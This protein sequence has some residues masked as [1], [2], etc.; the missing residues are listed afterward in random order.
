[1]GTYTYIAT[2]TMGLESLVAKEVRNL[3]YETTVENGKVI[4][5][6]GE[7]ALCR[8]NLWLRTSDRVKLKIGS[9]TATSFEELFEE[10]KNLPWEAFIPVY[11]E[12]PVVG[13]SVKSQLYSV[14]DCQRIVKKA[15]VERLKQTYNQS[16]FNEDGPLFKIEVALLKDEVTLTLDTTGDGLHKR[17]YRR[18]HSEAPLKETLASAMI[19]LTNW[20]PHSD[21]A[22]LDPFCGSGTI[23]IEAAM[24]AKNIAPGLKRSFQAEQ[25]PF[26]HEDTWVQAREEAR[27]LIDDA[28]MPAIYGS[29]R[30]ARMTKLASDNA[31]IAGVEEIEWKTK[32]IKDLERMSERGVLVCNPPYG[33]RMEERQSV[34]KLYETLGRVSQKQFPG[35]SVYVLSANEQ[36]ETFYGQNATKKRKLF[37]GNIKTDYYQFWAKK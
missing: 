28:H 1:M 12:F 33:T 7:E 15:V 20:R 3:G 35:W 18:L 4:F 37:N 10:T 13:R 2:A 30:D 17:G 26:I 11:G 32:D 29:D 14:P 6:G 24:M 25:W 27:D 8:S 23:P 22:F 19:M 16:W 34:Q 31:A 36:F 5:E 21:M 9:F